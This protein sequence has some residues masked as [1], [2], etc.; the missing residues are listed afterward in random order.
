MATAKKARPLSSKVR[1]YMAKHPNATTKQVC[2]ATGATPGYVYA[3]KSTMKKK[4]QS[5]EVLTVT[6]TGNEYEQKENKWVAV[7]TVAP[8]VAERIKAMRDGLDKL[9]VLNGGDTPTDNVNH[10]AHY[11]V[12]GIETIDFIEAKSLSYHLGNAVKYITRADHKGNKMEDLHKARWYLN[13]EIARLEGA[14]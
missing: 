9:E 7:A 4:H 13:R 3:I 10:P 8:S 6:G 1:L 12:G 2:D 11:K 14:K 5:A